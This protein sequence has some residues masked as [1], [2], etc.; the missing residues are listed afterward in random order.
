M[1]ENI[2][3]EDEKDCLQE[4]I[5]ISYGTASASISEILDSFATLKVPRIKLLKSLQLKD[6]L[7]NNDSSN[8][9]QFVVSQIIHGNFSGENIFLINKDSAFKLAEIL[10][11]DEDVN[12]EEVSDVVLEITNILSSATIGKFSELLDTKVSFQAPSLEIIDSLEDFNENRIK[13]FNEV[14][15]IST[16]LEFDKLNVKG[17]LILLTKDESIKKLK[18]ELQKILEEY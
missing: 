1:L 6:Y 9:I 7:I 5:N 4:L 11:E 15:I 14:I 16:I 18:D 17:E 10:N 13:D 2:L 12:I 8:D 3:N